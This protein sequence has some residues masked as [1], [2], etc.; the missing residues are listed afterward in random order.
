[1]WALLLWALRL[2]VRVLWRCCYRP[3]GASYSEKPPSNSLQEIVDRWTSAA[4][5]RIRPG[6]ARAP[7][8]LAAA[9]VHLVLAPA[10]PSSSSRAFP[11]SRFPVVPRFPPTITQLLLPSSPATT[12]KATT[13][14]PARRRCLPAHSNPPAQS[15]FSV[16]V[17]RRNTFLPFFP[18][19]VAPSLDLLLPPTVNLTEL[20]G[21]TVVKITTTISSTS[22]VTILAT[23]DYAPSRH[24]VAATRP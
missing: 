15:K 16:S 13:V 24:R 20:A 11:L 8:N 18:L 4:L 9:G 3:Q 19:A 14:P 7:S 23:Y 17:V 10:P 1:M 6:V 2:V 12:G 22:S 21:P 5:V